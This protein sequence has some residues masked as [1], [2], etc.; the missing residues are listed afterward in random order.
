M[1]FHVIAF[2]GENQCIKEELQSNQTQ[3]II[4]HFGRE[5]SDIYR[6][7]ATVLIFLNI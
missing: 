5:P 6:L 7:L 2:E 3:L 1:A 4:N